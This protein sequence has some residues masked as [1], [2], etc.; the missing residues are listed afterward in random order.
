MSR[1][2]WSV[3]GLPVSFARRRFVIGLGA[4]AAGLATAKLIPA[5]AEA[6]VAPGL[7]ASG[8]ALAEEALEEVWGH[9]P[10]YAAP[11]GF[12]RPR[13][14]G[15]VAAAEALDPQLAAYV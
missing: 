15:A 10:A 13:G 2:E 7:A 1:G 5:R 12:G 6:A 3:E 11:I 9:R 8:G 4:G 14:A